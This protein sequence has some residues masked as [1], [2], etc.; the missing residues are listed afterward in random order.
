MGEISWLAKEQSASQKGPLHGIIY[1]ALLP[2][3][4]NF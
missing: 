2:N 3:L 4:L 1:S